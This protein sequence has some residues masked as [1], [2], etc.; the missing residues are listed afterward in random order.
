MGVTLPS[1]LAWVLGL[2]GVDWPNADEDRFR[3]AASAYR[4]SAAEIDHART[5]GDLATQGLMAGN[6]GAH[7]DALAANWG[8]VSGEHLGRLVELLHLTA[9]GLDGLALVVEGAKAAVV[10]QL[11]VLAGELAAAA[12]SSIVTF[13][14]SDAA[15]L[16]ATQLTRVAVS[17][18]LR[19]A[20]EQLLRQAMAIVG[21]EVA[22][23]VAGLAKEAIQEEV[24]DY[25]GTGDG[26]HPDRIAAAGWRAGVDQAKRYADPATLAKAAAGVAVGAGRGAYARSE[27]GETG[28]TDEVYELD[29]VYEEA[30]G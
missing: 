21:S 20:E 6:S 30:D 16:A 24:S 15:A 5:R 26:P 11:G 4:Q 28:E 18:I 3:A 25:L 27:T 13:G 10:V 23:I 29:V 8:R 2:L 12:A 22:S 14:L 19:E 9:D 17:D 1:E 7:V